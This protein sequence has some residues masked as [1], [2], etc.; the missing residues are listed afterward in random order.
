MRS[1]A[2]IPRTIDL[3]TVN[4]RIFVNNA[5]LG[6]YAEIVASESYR[7]AKLRTTLDA[8]PDLLGDNAD[9]L[10]LHFVDAAVRSTTLPT[11]SWCPTT[12]TSLDS[13]GVSGPARAWTP[14]SSAWS[15]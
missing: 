5:S 9:A 13:L 10:D 3:A 2:G 14:A 8:L 4:G 7:D 11:S 1:H 12:R 6:L 15:R